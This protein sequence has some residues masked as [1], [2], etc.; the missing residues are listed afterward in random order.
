MIARVLRQS[1]KAPIQKPYWSQV[2]PLCCPGYVARREGRLE[3]MRSNT[4]WSV[5]WA[6]SKWPTVQLQLSIHAERFHPQKAVV[7]CEPTIK[8][9]E[10]GLFL[11]STFLFSSSILK[12]R[13]CWIHPAQ[14]RP[15]IGQKPSK[16]CAQGSCGNRSL[17]VACFA[18]ACS[19]HGSFFFFS[20]K[21]PCAIIEKLEDFVSADS[22]QLIWTLYVLEELLIASFEFRRARILFQCQHM[23]FHKP[24][25]ALADGSHRLI[26]HLQWTEIVSH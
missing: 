23:G 17:T 11:L 4:A 24:S 21:V 7:F 18:L 5:W 15:M 2:W 6:W 25:F 22:L 19:F 1:F 9:A 8:N 26:K 20:A 13:V 14:D 16:T 3:L 10:A 12:L